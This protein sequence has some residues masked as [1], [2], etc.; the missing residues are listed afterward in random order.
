M[1]I[2]PVSRR[3]QVQVQIFDPM[4]DTLIT[5]M[6]LELYDVIKPM[7]SYNWHLKTPNLN[8]EEDLEEDGEYTLSSGVIR[9]M[10]KGLIEFTFFTR[11]VDDDEY[12]LLQYD[13]FAIVHSYHKKPLSNDPDIGWHWEEIF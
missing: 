5:K 10:Q 4:P 9:P 3:Y 7:V 12:S 11:A 13:M 8:I 2:L 6:V 1:E